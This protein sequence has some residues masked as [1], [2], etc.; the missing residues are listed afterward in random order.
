M[1][2]ELILEC[3][4]DPGS[5]VLD[6]LSILGL[7]AAFYKSQENEIPVPGPGSRSQSPQVFLTS[8]KF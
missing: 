7:H 1:E 3:F 4:R 2:D 6:F 8:E 5:V